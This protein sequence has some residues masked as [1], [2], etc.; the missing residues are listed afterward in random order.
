MLEKTS[1]NYP[2]TP[3][4]PDSG[5]RRFTRAIICWVQAMYFCIGFKRKEDNIGDTQKTD[6]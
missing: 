1:G 3:V 5:S 4:V 2:D 6:K